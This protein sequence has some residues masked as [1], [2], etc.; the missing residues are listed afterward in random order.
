MFRK[1][2][3]NL[4]LLA[5]ALLLVGGIFMLPSK[6][7][8]DSIAEENITQV[9]ENVEDGLWVDTFDQVSA[10]SLDTTT[11]YGQAAYKI[12]SREDLAFVAYM[13]NMGGQGNLYVSA[14]Y[15]L[16]CNLDLAGA[17]WT[18]IGTASSPFAGVFYG[19]GY[20]ISNISINEYSWGGE[21]LNSGAGLFGNVS[22]TICD[23]TVSGWQQINVS[24]ESH[25]YV[26]SLVGV[27]DGG[28]VYNCYDI[29]ST[30]ID[31]TGSSYCSIG[32]AQNATIARGGLRYLPS[33]S[34]YYTYT[35]QAEMRD[36][37]TVG[38]SNSIRE[39]FVVVYKF[40]YQN[41]SFMKGDDQW[42][43]PTTLKVLM[44]TSLNT[45]AQAF[46]VG[47]YVAQFPVLRENASE[48]D[49]YVYKEGYKAVLDR[50]FYT[51]SENDFAAG[52]VK[53]IVATQE[54][55]QV[56]LDHN[57]GTRGTDGNRIAYTFKYDQSFASFFNG[58]TYNQR[59]GYDFKG[60]FLNAST[61]MDATTIFS[62]ANTNPSIEKSYINCFPTADGIYY[63]TWEFNEN[64]KDFNV[65]YA[66]ASDEGGIFND[67]SIAIASCTAAE[68]ITG[69]SSYKFVVTTKTGFQITD[70]NE[71][72]ESTVITGKK[73]D[74]TSG[75]YVNFNKNTGSNPSYRVNHSSL[76]NDYYLPVSIQGVVT[77][78]TVET[79]ITYEI[80]V[81][82][83]CGPGGAVWL[84]FERD[85]VEIE[86]DIT[87]DPD[88]TTPVSHTTSILSDTIVT[89]LGNKDSQGN[90]INLQPDSGSTNAYTMQGSVSNLIV[91]VRRGE[92]PK[93][94]LKVDAQAGSV[95]KSYILAWDFGTDLT[96]TMDENYSVAETFDDD[97]NKTFYYTHYAFELNT[98]S[99]VG[100]EKDSQMSF[101]IGPLRTK[102]SVEL[103]KEDGTALAADE[104]E[105]IGVYINQSSSSSSAIQNTSGT[106]IPIID[107][108][109]FHVYSNGKYQASRVTVDEVKDVAAAPEY[110]SDFST[111]M[112]NFNLRTCTPINTWFVTPYINGAAGINYEVK[113]YFEERDYNVTF[114]FFFEGEAITQSSAGQSN[115]ISNLIK[116]IQKSYAN[117]KPK[118]TLDGTF[119]M[120]TEGLGALSYDKIEIVNTIG[121]SDVTTDVTG[122]TLS[123]LADITQPSVANGGL[124]EFK[125][126]LG[127]YNTIIKVHFNYRKVNFIVNSL[128]VSGAENVLALGANTLAQ[129]TCE[130]K[131]KY[132]NTNFVVYLT[133]EVG[134][135]SIHTQYY[136]IG[137][138]LQNGK[139]VYSGD[140]STY[141]GFLK[142]ST[143]VNDIA[144]SGGATS[145]ESFAYSGISAEVGKRIVQV[146]YKPGNEGDGRIYTS[147]QINL[148]TGN[149]SAGTVYYA[150]EL[151]LSTTEFY[152]L[153]HVFKNYNPS[154]GLVSGNL[155]SGLVYSVEGDDWNILF[156]GVSP[157]SSMKEWGEFISADSRTVMLLTEWDK[158]K[159]HLDIDDGYNK[160]FISIGDP[161]YYTTDQSRKDG[162]ARFFIG[163]DDKTG[164]LTNVH[165]GYVV[166]GYEIKQDGSM[167]RNGAGIEN[168]L[169]LTPDNFLAFINSD[170]RFVQNTAATPIEINLLFNNATYL[171]Y[172]ANS[173][174]GYYEY[175]W[176][177]TLQ[178][179]MGQVSPAGQITINVTYGLVPE[180]L[181][182]AMAEGGPLKIKRQGYEVQGWAIAVNGKQSS[183]FDTSATYL[184]AQDQ[185]IV[186]I[187]KRVSETVN[188]G[189]K[190]ATDVGEKRDFYLAKS[191][192]ILLGG[193]SYNSGAF[194][195]T[196]TNTLILEN[197]EMITSFAFVVKNDA[198]L[199]ESQIFNYDVLQ[200]EGEYFIAFKVAV[201]DTLNI[202]AKYPAESYYSQ[203]DIN[204]TSFKVHK[205]EIYF[206]D[207]EFHT[208]YNGTNEFVEGE[209]NEFGSFLYKFD[210]D[211][212]DLS[213]QEQAIGDVKTWFDNFVVSS[214]D[215]NAGN[216]KELTMNLVTT[217]NK[218]GSLILSD[219]FSNVTMKEENVYTITVNTLTIDKA[220]FVITFPSGSAYLIDGM[221][222]I[223]F[224]NDSSYSFVVGSVTFVYDYDKIILTPNSQGKYN[225]GLYKGSGDDPDLDKANFT[226]ID[227]V[228]TDHIDDRD[229]NFEWVIAE[230]S[231]FNLLDASNALKLDYS[232]RYLTA[233]DGI[234]ASSL[235]EN[236]Q[237][238]VDKMS[239][240]NV[241]LDGNLISIPSDVDF[242][243]VY[244]ENDMIAYIAGINT[245][246]IYVYINRTLL[247]EHSLSYQ[248]VVNPT[249]VRKQTLKPLV[250][251]ESTTPISTIEQSFDEF[252]ADYINHVTPEADDL[253][254]SYYVVLT[255]STKIAID[256]NSG[257]D[258]NGNESVTL[259]TSP[260]SA[261]TI[262]NPTN[263]YIG[264]KFDG[265]ELPKNSIISL[266]SGAGQTSFSNSCGGKLHEVIAKWKFD[267]IDGTLNKNKIELLAS[268]KAY[269]LPLNGTD[270]ILTLVLPNEGVKQEKYTLTSGTN[271]YAY[272]NVNR[273]FTLADTN[274]HLTTSMSG[275]Y[276]LTVTVVYNDGVTAN[277]SVT[278]SYQFEISISRSKIELVYGGDNLVFANT[279]QENKVSF[280]YTLNGENDET[281]VLSALLSKNPYRINASIKDSSNKDSHLFDAGIYTLSFSIDS[282]YTDIYEINVQIGQIVAG[283]VQ[284]SITIEIE[285][286][287]IVLSEY[288]LSIESQLR[289][290][291]GAP[292]AAKLKAIVTIEE[293]LD[294]EVGL[295]FE[296]T[297]KSEAIGKY[298]V[299]F[300]EIESADD[301]Q[302]YT[303]NTANA[304]IDYTIDA[305]GGVLKIS[306]E[307]FNFAYTYNG[308]AISTFTTSTGESFSLNAKSSTNNPSIDCKFSVYY[309][310]GVNKVYVPKSEYATYAT[311]FTF[312]TN[313]QADVG[314]YELF[315]SLTS[316]G[317][318]Y[319][320]GVE[321]DNLEKAKV[322]VNKAT[323]TVVEI[324]KTFD[325]TDAVKFNNVITANN[326]C[327][328]TLN[329]LISG[330]MIEI[331]GTLS[332]TLVGS[333]TITSLYL[334]ETGESSNYNLVYTT[335]IIKILPST[336]EVLV[337]FEDAGEVE[338]GKIAK[339][340]T[341]SEIIGLLPLEFN[342]GNIIG[343]YISVTKYEVVSPNY[344]SSES[345]KAGTYTFKFTL[346]SKN[347]T[348]ESSPVA[349]LNH[350]YTKVVDLEVKVNQKAITITNSSNKITKEYDGYT[351][352][353]ASFFGNVNAGF[354]AAEGLIA[355]D[356]VSITYAEYIDA[357]IGADKQIV[358]ATIAGADKDNYDITYS[359]V[360]DITKVTLTF[361][362]NGDTITFVDGVQE[363]E[364]DDKL[365]VVYEGNIN[366]MI[367]EIIDEDNYLS[368]VG[369]TQIG[370]SYNGINFI[371]MT[372]QQKK[373]FLQDAVD[374]KNVGLS[375]D[376]IWQINQV[377]V[378]FISPNAEVFIESAKT[379]EITV[380]YYTSFDKI[381]IKGSTGYKFAGYKLSNENAVKAI[382]VIDGQNTKNANLKITNVL[383][384]VTITLTIA[385]I[386]IKVIIEY[387]A[388]AGFIVTTDSAAWAGVY[389]RTLT[390]SQAR[391]SDLPELKV[392]EEKTYDFSHWTLD[393][394]VNSGSNI[395]ER[396]SGDSLSTDNLTGFTFVAN[397]TESELTL[398]LDIDSEITVEVK[399]GSDT[400]TQIEGKVIFHYNDTLTLSY[401]VIDW[402][403]CSSQTITSGVNISQTGNTFTFSTIQQ[404]FTVALRAKL[405]E[406]NFLTSFETPEG[407]LIAEDSGS[408]S[409]IYTLDSHE[410][411]SDLLAVYT[412]SVGTYVQ[413]KWIYNSTEIALD[414]EIK[415]L[416]ISLNGSIPTEDISFNLNAHFQGLKYQVT[417]DKGLE[418]GAVFNAPDDINAQTAVREF[419]YGEMMKGLPTIYK[420]GR[421]YVYTDANGKMFKEGYLLTTDLNNADLKL[422][423]TAV[424]NFIPCEV[425]IV[426]TDNSDKVISTTYSGSTYTAP[427]AVIYGADLTFNFNL[428][429]G[430]EIN[431]DA[432]KT[433][434]STGSNQTLISIS[435]NKISLSNIIEDTVITV[436]VKAKDYTLTIN[437]HSYE[438][439]SNT[440][441]D[442]SYDQ[443]ISTIFDGQSFSRD[444]Y[445]LAG[446]QVGEEKF[447]SYSGGWI[448]DG[449]FTESGVYKY[450]GDLLLTLVW[451]Y[452]AS[453]KYIQAVTTSVNNLY[454][455][456]SEQ[457][458]ARTGFIVTD[459]QDFEINKTFTN[460]DKVKEV[461]YMVD[462]NKAKA[463][464]DFSL[465]S[466]DY[467]SANVYIVA[468]IEDT[469]TGSTYQ[470]ASN[471]VSVLLNKTEVNIVDAVLESYYN[472]T[473]AINYTA[474]TNLGQIYFH[475][476]TILN[477]ELSIAYVEI[478]DPTGL[479]SVGDNYQVKYFFT[480][481]AAFNSDNYTGLTRESGHYILTT[482]AMVDKIYAS[483]IK[484]TVSLVFNEQGYYNGQVHKVQDISTILPDFA[485]LFNVNITSIKTISEAI[486]KYTDTAQFAIDAAVVNKDGH[487]RTSNFTFVVNG[488]FEIVSPDN[489]YRVDYTT[490]YLNLASSPAL[491][492]LASEMLAVTSFEYGGDKATLKDESLSFSTSGKLIFTITNNGSL[493]QYI[494]VTKG[495]NVKF[496]FK[497]DDS[498]EDVLKFTT[499]T[500]SSDEQ[501]LVEALQNLTVE[502]PRTAALTVVEATTY[503]AVV[504][505]YKAIKMS[506]GDKGGDQGYLYI[507]KGGS[508]S[509]DTPDEWTGFEFT[510][511]ENGVT[512]TNVTING[513]NVEVNGNAD[514]TTGQIVANWVLVNPVATGK[515][516]AFDAKVDLSAKQT[517]TLADITTAGIENQNNEI[518]YSYSY[519]KAGVEISTSENLALAANTNSNGVYTLTITAAYKFYQT[520][521]TTIQFEITVNRLTISSYSLS[522]NSFVYQNK[523]FASSITVTLN[524]T[525]TETLSKLLSAEDS[526]YY[527][528]ITQNGVQSILKDAGEYVLT[529]NVNEAIFDK[530]SFA[531]DF[532]YTKTVTINQATLEVV[533]T[534][535]PEAISSKLYLENDPIFE[536]EKTMFEGTAEA[537]VVRITLTRE[538]GESVGEYAFTSG[539]SIN[540]NY[541]I[542][543]K[544][545]TVFTI[546]QSNL[547]L[548]I[549]M[550]QNVSAVYSKSAPDFVLSFDETAGKWIVTLGTTSS[551]LKLTYFAGETEVALSGALYQS[552]L[553]GVDFVTNVVNANSYTGDDIAV[554]A[555]AGQQGNFTDYKVSGAFT[556]SQLALVIS[557]VEKKFDRTDEILS[558]G[559]EFANLIAGDSVSLL[560]NYSSVLA[561]EG[562]ALKNLVLSGSAASNYSIANPEFL[563]KITAAEVNSISFALNKT[564]FVYGVL[565]KD[566]TI[567]DLLT[568]SQG[569]SFLNGSVSDDITKGYI[570]ISSFTVLNTNLSSSGHIKAGDIQIKVILTSTNFY[571]FNGDG[572]A[573]NIKVEK[574]QM[575]LSYLN[576]VKQ[577]DGTASLPN[578]LSASLTGYIMEGDDVQIDFTRSGFED[579]DIGE[580]KKVKIEITGDDSANYSVID[581]VKGTITAY[582]ITFKVNAST[583]HADLVTDGKFV[584]D[585]QTAIVDASEFK[586]YYPSTNLAS[587]TLE[588]LTFPQRKG[589]KATGWKYYDASTTSY[590]PITAENLYDILKIITEDTANTEKTLN[591]FTVWE[592]QNYNLNIQNS[593]IENI[594]FTAT[595]GKVEGD[596]ENGFTAR[597]FSS[598][599]MTVEAKRGYKIQSVN[600]AKGSVKSCDLSDVGSTSGTYS[601]EEIGS[602]L[603][604]EIV[605][606][607]LKVT[608]TIDANMPSYTTRTD[609]YELKY[610]YTYT[611]LS[612][613]TE[614]NLPKL[615]VTA[616]TYDFVGYN[617]AEGKLIGTKTLKDVVDEIYTTLASDVQITLEAQWLG[618]NY[619]ITFDANGGT[620]HGTGAKTAEISAVYGSSISQTFPVAIKPGERNIWKC[621][622]VVYSQNDDLK[623]IGVENNG[624]WRVTFVA[625]WTYNPFTL[626]VKFDDKLTV[627]AN[628]AAISNGE[629]FVVIYNSTQIAFKVSAEVGYEFI[630]DD[631]NLNG[632][633]SEGNGNIIVENLINDGE[634][635]FSSIPA[636]NTLTIFTEHVESVEAYLVENGSDTEIEI[637]DG[638][639]TAYTESVVKLVFKALK[640]WSFAEKS[641]VFSGNGVITHSFS[642]DNKTLTITWS[643]FVE[644]ATLSINAEADNITATVGDVS[645]IFK[646]LTI[647]GKTLK[648]EG[649]S[650]IVKTG[651]EVLVTGALAY[652][653]KDGQIETS[654]GSVKEGSV[655]NILS[656]D[657]HYIFTATIVDF[658]ENFTLSFS[659]SERE[660]SFSI[661]V[662]Q[663]DEEYGQITS[664]SSQTVKFGQILD[665]SQQE[666]IETY[667]FD[668]WLYGE[669]EE[670][671]IQGNA[672]VTLTEEY[673]DLLE[674][675]PEGQTIVVK[676]SYKR[677]VVKI[678]FTAIGNGE[679]QVSQGIEDVSFK[680]EKGLSVTKTIYMGQN[681][682]FVI[683][684][685][686]GYEIGKL[687]INDQVENVS[688]YG[689]DETTGKMSIFIE[690]DSTINSITIEFV[691]SEAKV[692]VQSGVRVNYTENM[693][694]TAGGYI[695]I[696]D[697]TGLKLGEE[698]Y[699]QGKLGKVLIGGDYSIVSYTNATLYFTVEVKSGF[700]FTVTGSS[701]LIINE[702]QGENGRVYSFANVKDESE[703]KVVFTAKE[704]MINVKFAL[705]GETQ[706]VQGGV[707]NVDTSSNFVSAM[708]NRGSSLGI[709]V[710]TGADL[711][712]KVNA[713]LAYSLLADEN[714]KLK[715]TIVYSD[716]TSSFDEGQIVVG[717]VEAS[718]SMLTG[719]T[720]SA[721]FSVGQV[722]MGATIIFY[723]EPRE[724]TIQF[725]LYNEFQVLMTQKVRYGQEWS[726][727]FMSEEEK[728][729]IFANRTGYTF[730]GYYTMPNGQGKQYIDR[731]GNVV[732]RWL[733]DGYSYNGS[734]YDLEPN[735]ND[736]TTTFTLY[737][738]WVYNRADV[739]IQFTPAEVTNV[740][741][742]NI[743]NVITNIGSLA[744]WIS[745]DNDWY[746]E[747]VI[748]ATLQ[749]KAIDFDG[750]EFKN[751]LVY[752]E[753]GEG[754]SKPA[755][756][757]LD[758]LEM[759]SYILK[760]IYQPKFELSVVNE[761]NG[762]SDGGTI[763]LLQEGR[764]VSGTSFESDK[765]VTLQA[766]P[767]NGYKFLYFVDNNTGLKMNGQIDAN[768][769][770]TYTYSSLVTRAISV[771]AVFTG[772]PIAVSLDLEEILARH[773]LIS[774]EINGK[775]CDITQPITALV[776][777]TITVTA[778]KNQGYAF[779]VSG[780]SFTYTVEKSV[781]TFTYTFAVKDL[782][783]VDS[784][785]Y[786]I[787]IKFSSTREEIRYSFKIEL[788][789]KIDENEVGK[790][791]YLLISDKTSK[792]ISVILG[793]F[794]TYQFGQDFTLK[795]KANENYQ[796]IKVYLYTTTGV[797]D[798]SDN[799]VDG[800]LTFNAEMMEVYFDYEINVV[801]YYDRLVWTEVRSAAFTGQGTKDN[802][803]VLKTAADFALLSYL[804]NNG[805]ETEDGLAYADAHYAVLNDIDFAGRFFEPIGTKENPF[806]GTI[807][808]GR[809]EFKNVSHYMKYENPK[810]SYNGLFWHLGKNAKIIQENSSVWIIIV[811]IACG[812]ALIVAVLVLILLLRKRRKKQLEQLA[813]QS[814]ILE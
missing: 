379:T 421:Q 434:I 38:Y 515:D 470:V 586:L 472:E 611:E 623:S 509:A 220:R 441:F 682:D 447:A 615:S 681:L 98:L 588:S 664:A 20:E 659:S 446:L 499:W 801:A 360:G 95:A 362:K 83:L 355:N 277:Q 103:L 158:I 553:T 107:A 620:F 325:Q 245:E 425:K 70:L 348:F 249:S 769:I 1:A 97:S 32:L 253:D 217:S 108:N 188:A 677:K 231:T 410:K 730:L 431:V 88:I 193:I 64:Y 182:N 283:T 329:G 2:I 492:A 660:Y 65:N 361:I 419:V 674:S 814:T 139:V 808:L 330:D 535:I 175:E 242:Y 655:S 113:I 395:W 576:I 777:D 455:N 36:A 427:V 364:N 537:E 45:A 241:Y 223:V 767:N 812:V 577:F 624:V 24:T 560:G 196:L 575:D 357:T 84:V 532:E 233:Q 244:V 219:Y 456:G 445:K 713:S 170:N 225:T 543:I 405:I 44:S 320:T 545:G 550:E 246:K 690:L 68:R 367:D 565:H 59:Q 800:N 638:K 351:T 618:E 353:L 195:K 484:T 326:N 731:Y 82:H 725:N 539:V 574:K 256:F 37:L 754:V 237:A 724:Y 476:K 387:N 403:R 166:V 468:I 493:G 774:V 409:G 738:N 144:A 309:E 41:G 305:P 176:D 174:E 183:V 76:N 527:F 528:A 594:T 298:R 793:S 301:K 743:R 752:F 186:P 280:A 168:T 77:S 162:Q 180:N 424:W 273:A 341:I 720:N 12:S 512:T 252:K 312:T 105:G 352:V 236:Y 15:I 35:S 146:E 192:D 122:Y 544:D 639:L 513:N 804:V 711:V 184:Y 526:S 571:G 614:D 169:N 46:A 125:I 344:S 469:H 390:Y 235:A 685:D 258:A 716:E 502:T 60:L 541:V 581:N 504:T 452:D 798:I 331:E 356:I 487:D 120:T 374:A 689:Y 520:K 394:N 511:W 293:N 799:V 288:D 85:W 155:S 285:K 319:W 811:V 104:Y 185:Y 263:E 279:N 647:N 19:E 323:L 51:V 697:S 726:T 160:T 712:L 11:A 177:T 650:V 529:L 444:G 683:T 385:E 794:Y 87:V 134:N 371:D 117:Q 366:S 600:L 518:T 531:A 106:L 399:K 568:H 30:K 212:S 215:F 640:G 21:A 514:I 286:Y 243:S 3:K 597:Y 784:Q 741:S 291:F 114:E 610:E 796:L 495:E 209:A 363:F 714:G 268:E 216:S 490:R 335:A 178:G 153:G 250:W 72:T 629:K 461:Y 407:T 373:D 383:D 439:I 687:R 803:F 635:V 783:V 282:D 167:T 67:P 479:Y 704:N 56:Y 248:L 483:I 696:T 190:F 679:Y 555:L 388:P 238:E 49:I 766:I 296:R 157:A 142:N 350:V 637:T 112:T 307:L 590:K 411:L 365:E 14:N 5:F 75:V 474:N 451:E 517:V 376:A 765:T 737:A 776:G 628:N 417:F 406:V 736:Q 616:G 86:T 79:G 4:Y 354:Y 448:F 602:D 621:G 632:Q 210:W 391:L 53:D 732:S 402:Y 622:E 78:G 227:L 222:P 762:L 382:S 627:L 115:Y 524:G 699:G 61:E 644:G 782:I 781:Y 791:G 601:F 380:D 497:L 546:K 203:T 93:I 625:E 805:I 255:D 649:D 506:L 779:D 764:V 570:S 259:Y 42:Y 141:D 163:K 418:D 202:L 780:G 94:Q 579:G 728:S 290:K 333:A 408:I 722:N 375:I 148:A 369:Y 657:R 127:S 631:A 630:Y 9:T 199:Y 449:S 604:I 135:I 608:F 124:C 564:N 229:T 536:I 710:I 102:I 197:G 63:F 795:M 626:T 340:S 735:F 99:S 349:D 460:G 572:Y 276:T 684:P 322:I 440:T 339:T 742:F 652:G 530:T 605:T 272:S 389:E 204:N 503:Y 232:P 26:G 315:V 453:A 275:I 747:I 6:K 159:Y 761:H 123:T 458:I 368:R 700:T 224:V 189:I 596:M 23:V 466:K 760:A 22:G 194:D 145:G 156:D 585:G 92:K 475:D 809:F 613:L 617:Y 372:D 540:K 547:T 771:T 501:T 119:T 556:I 29:C 480:F 748:G 147:D 727:D 337:S 414:Q 274:G 525:V 121:D 675:V 733:E 651:S 676:A 641:I 57:Y 198:N 338:Y 693:G 397:W 393:G 428:S 595:K 669:N 52:L 240:T 313:A 672:Q 691:A 521:S 129:L 299:T 17:L 254:A 294:D 450:D 332:T 496:N 665:L 813:T 549:A 686:E 213:T 271:S 429:V 321:F 662:R 34:S 554:A 719:Y 171:L 646:T 668:K 698:L 551:T 619:I 74:K 498:S 593:N 200:K 488:G 151:S 261:V 802:P 589:Y 432:S 314:E 678:N 436:A 634:I 485:T 381:E 377:K 292:E 573:V 729:A 133:G 507:K 152:N 797:F 228:I 128:H 578:H 109:F 73:S 787:D 810:T 384:D 653:F 756:F 400:L 478:V 179:N 396:I 583:E 181:T 149:V 71:K 519:A 661:S 297:N 763:N 347:Y 587:D 25:G 80:T 673:K 422:T 343:E 317:A 658:D 205:N 58:T 62:P 705:D 563:G 208:I 642:A 482:S 463:Q 667:M 10:Y 266:S 269:E 636:A 165:N 48:T 304:E 7:G 96:L 459:A 346:A 437:E 505:D 306:S 734:T 633:I 522:S 792:E 270:G 454:Y 278:T 420:E 471:E 221:T 508:E 412:A 552:A 398:T 187:W 206:F 648:L 16:T 358:N 47:P 703:I 416:I 786:F 643:L 91:R 489:A 516:F 806:N 692:Y 137:W 90:V 281:V 27:L 262:A 569:Y 311:Y 359:L 457:T 557:K 150:E 494:L 89:K 8:E 267:K 558:S 486:A 695:Y 295:I 239:I 582:V 723:V 715:Y 316:E 386:E 789:E 721:D 132:D 370:Y 173:Q 234:L 207:N 18:P 100:L 401:S 542:T 287:V 28:K 717:Q 559:V 464:N 775:E 745:Q 116:D 43:T 191:H 772:K 334:T 310:D 739:T 31:Y 303:V 757:Q 172:L 768:G 13:V 746:A 790:A 467:I 706:L 603:K 591:I 300:K 477:S 218:F 740:G 336:E 308:Q 33:T 759:G 465:I 707:I 538:M 164:S 510:G 50:N 302:N 247:G 264:L 702:Y 251:T 443:N 785:S 562:I 807:N 671:A 534:D 656:T 773:E 110:S 433:F 645:G 744:A 701:G 718:E 750:Y 770:A 598:F 426:F 442:V 211:G 40:N 118:Q 758:K 126:N 751:W 342:D 284:T 753:G 415:P 654:D 324:N 755:S 226:I 607:K 523:D 688:E 69:T 599:Q 154:T 54:T 435:S 131:F 430:Y 500:T 666:L 612:S 788:E 143:F 473:N 55:I 345:L 136:L 130:L 39:F 289:K 378:K 265:Y 138:Y 481:N 462:G 709:S 491:E 140:G 230:E 606:I 161:V 214:D 404:D 392:T 663:G 592:I 413:D 584:N 438:S 328:M 778:K 609:T 201:T 257:K 566:T 111:N 66:I 81:N 260:L 567:T 708:P 749:I 548:F 318:K 561:G 423:L 670:L 101:F 580:N 694:T 533:Q 327:T 680:I